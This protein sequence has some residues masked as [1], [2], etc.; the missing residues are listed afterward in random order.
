[1]I[2]R[3][4]IRF[5]TAAATLLVLLLLTTGAWGATGV[6]ASFLVDT[7]TIP[8]GG[9]VNF[10]AS[11]SLPSPDA[12]ITD[13]TWD[14][15]DGTGAMS[16]ATSPYADH[17]YV[18]A[19]EYDVVLTVT[20]DSGMQD[21][22][23]ATRISVVAN[24][25]PVSVPTADPTSGTVPLTVSFDGSGSYDP[26]GNIEY[27]DWEFG[28]GIG[29]DSS[30]NPT[31]E[32]AYPG[33]F[34]ASLEVTDDDY[35]TASDTVTITVFPLVANDNF[36]DAEAL[37]GTLEET[38]GEV[39][40][41]NVGATGEPNEDYTN[42]AM[43]P[44]D[45]VWYSFTPKTDGGLILHVPESSATMH[46]SVYA[47]SS[48]GDTGTGRVADSDP[49]DAS[50]NV[51]CSVTAD[52]TYYIQL[53]GV[54]DAEGT[55]T[56]SWE[57]IGPPTNDN[58]AAATAL[59]TNSGT[60]EGHTWGATGETDEPA[61]ADQL[62]TVWYRWSPSADGVLSLDL[63]GDLDGMLSVHT[64]EDVASLTSLASDWGALSTPVQAGTT[65]YIQVDGES[66]DEGSFTLVWSLSAA[67]D[68]DDLANAEA[69][70]SEDTSGT[71]EGSTVAA[72]EETEESGG[73][74]TL[75]SVWYTF[76]RTTNGLLSLGGTEVGT[77][78]PYLGV[79]TGAVM[80]ELIYVGSGSPPLSVPIRAGKT[81]SIQVDG[82]G[83][84]VGTFAL[85]WLFVE[86]PGN[87]DFSAATV[88]SNDNGSVDGT[89]IAAT[90]EPD[91]NDPYAPLNTV[92]YKWVAP[93]SGVATFDMPAG[94][95]DT[96][97]A[98]YDGDGTF[99]DL[100]CLTDDD[101]GSP[102]GEYLSRVLFDCE[103]DATYWLQVDGAGDATGNFTLSWSLQESPSN[104]NFADAYALTGTYGTVAGTNIAATRES[105]EPFLY[106]DNSVW[107]SF[108]PSV[109]GIMDL[110]MTNP[111]PELLDTVL[112]VWDIDSVD[113][114]W[115]ANVAFDDDSGEELLSATSFDA[116]AGITYHI[117]II[118][119]HS[120][121]EGGFTLGWQFTAGVS[122]YPF[123][124][125][126]DHETF[127]VGVQKSFT[128]T[129]T[130]EA[131]LTISID[132]VYWPDLGLTFTDNL[133]GTATIA[134]IPSAKSGG[135]YNVLVRAANSRGSTTQ[136]FTLT[137]N[138]AAG[139]TNQ[140]ESPHKT[141]V[142]QPAS[143]WV[144]PS[145]YPAPT[146][147]WEESTDAGVTWTPI[148]GATGNIY[149]I[150]STTLAMDHYQYR[151]VV[152]NT[153]DTVISDPIEL[154]VYQGATIT[155]QPTSQEAVVGHP[156]TFSVAASG[157]P[158]PLYQWQISTSK[159]RKWADIVGATSASY[160]TDPT[161]FTM[162]GYLYRVKVS[163]DW[164]DVTS[165]QV[166]LTVRYGTTDLAVEQDGEYDSVTK[167][168]T[169]TWTV[170]N[171]G[172]EDAQNVVLKSTLANGTK[173][174]NVNLDQASGATS[175]VGGRTVTIK[176]PVLASGSS[177][178]I[179]VTALVTRATGIVSNTVV[180]T[181]AGTDTA[182]DNNSGTTTIEIGGV[183]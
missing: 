142:G 92:W 76:S 93:A 78:T 148:E 34:T 91:E 141:V 61:A 19:G 38:S 179:V 55:F 79:Y 54:G 67:P 51:A 154:Q 146:V 129:A 11:G 155:S 86:A 63:T 89:N 119:K 125:S 24:Q 139:I 57:F 49:T 107:Y 1:M 8:P 102:S 110:T 126:A 183:G 168:I 149:E 174:T 44:L 166:A 29:G 138:E 163:N 33:T 31:H 118:G 134:G 59:G 131:P 130:G 96:A 124:T 147:Q 60:V 153:I 16:T 71:I 176:I 58:F 127:A 161:T 6:T 97:L 32:Y 15:G 122:Y 74:G 157:H 14:Y 162:S 85:E 105:T 45:T 75:N 114:A 26:D 39:T 170:S 2:R 150:E 95:F 101:N 28:D 120:S 113:E 159:G 143:L 70:S 106:A 121:E 9:L 7:D 68:N 48:V 116:V 81:Y 175:K 167:K 109:S 73:D 47:A 37:E 27:W 137:I 13:F 30:M 21:T 180:L 43:P 56:L 151:A 164:G 65:Y 46:L 103:K 156:A 82:S 136:D 112:I 69:I 181:S 108:T 4:V 111:D 66:D 52:T 169:W 50:G 53:D 133:D 72:T 178:T 83:D 128:L 152:T 12:S 17:Q 84:E 80:A 36:A 165:N 132:N 177:A 172:D 3:T 160:T 10:D 135:A 145:G 98:A 158:D 99:A 90:G 23:L 171:N 64:G 22:S 88:I 18:S 173:L 25:L 123:I 35:D 94:D 182:P 115:G 62:D 20:D 140:T 77:V 42:V 104:D 117:Q 100:Y 40:G 87:D 5:A 144:S 41:T